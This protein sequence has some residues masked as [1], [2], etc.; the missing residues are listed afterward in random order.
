M[1]V[2]KIG[3]NSRSVTGDFSSVKTKKTHRFESTLERD[4]IYLMEFDPLVVD[5]DPQPIA[6]PYINSGGRKSKYVPDFKVVYTKK[7]AQKKGCKF[8]LVEI[9]YLD[10]LE[11]RREQ[12]AQGFKAAESY[13][14][15]E[16]GKFEIFHDGDIRTTRLAGSI[17]LHRYLHP[18]AAPKQNIDF[19]ALAKEL[20]IFTAKSWV[21]KIE[22]SQL[23]KGQALSNLWHLIAIG[24]LEIDLDIPISMKSEI[25]IAEK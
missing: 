9:K 7:G 21:D 6:F 5:Y 22:G 17:F 10:E 25:R 4:F 23:I 11:E 12:F 18:S 20:K 2:R 3:M 16:G 19:M 15:A 14:K 13:C 1:P 8:S 24:Q